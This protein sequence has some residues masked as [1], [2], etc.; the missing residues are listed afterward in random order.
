MAFAVEL[1]EGNKGRIFDASEPGLEGGEERATTVEQMN[2]DQ[3]RALL[4]TRASLLSRLRDVGQ[5]GSWREFFDLYWKLIYN[6]ARKRGL[7]ATEAEEVV[8]ETMISL[9]KE[10]PTFRYDPRKGSFKS[11]LMHITYRRIADQVRKR[12]NQQVLDE[13]IEVEADSDFERSWMEEWQQNLIE[14]AVCRV[15]E[16]TSPHVFQVYSLCVLQNKG[17]RATARILKMSVAGVYM[18]SFK[19]NKLIKAEV[20]KLKAKE[21]A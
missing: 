6:A 2:G 15:R 21:Q 7:T 17:V 10:M 20:E 4:P 13:N 16:R 5:D 12:K 3:D 19:V 14:T 8:Q 18:A 1:K 11:W 9:M